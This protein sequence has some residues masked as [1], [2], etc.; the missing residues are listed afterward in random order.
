MGYRN[1]HNCNFLPNLELTA[2]EPSNSNQVQALKPE[3]HTLSGDK[4]RFDV[5]NPASININDIATA[6][7]NICRYTG[8]VDTHYN[9]AQHSILVS[10]LVP[11]EYAMEALLHDA[12]EAYCNDIASPLKA[13]LPDYRLIERR[14]DLVI[15]EKFGLPLVESPV[16][17]KADII[18]LVTEMRSFGMWDYIDERKRIQYPPADFTV[19][20]EPPRQARVRFISRYIELGGVIP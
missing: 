13:L 5:I 3:I 18:M 8:H 15:R 7:S 14:I 10:R 19:T 4:F 6:L 16:V 11:P 12:T 9:V 2:Q 20:P 17:K 1:N